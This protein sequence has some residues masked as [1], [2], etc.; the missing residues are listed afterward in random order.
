MAALP[1]TR[2]A[3][4]WLA[5]ATAYCGATLLD[6][7]TTAVALGSGLHEGNPVMAPFIGTFGLG[8]QVVVSIGLCAVLTWYA[9]RGGGRLVYVLAFVR[10]IVVL[11]NILQL[12]MANR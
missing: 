6:L 3:T 4:T 11:N 2:P 10:W 1:R 9:S 7:L 5:P 12:I 8:P